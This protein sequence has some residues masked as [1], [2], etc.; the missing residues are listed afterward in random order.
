MASM[1][2]STISFTESCVPERNVQT[3]PLEKYSTQKI[4]TPKKYSLLK[5]FTP[6]NGV[7]G[8]GLV[9]R[10]G[11]GGRGSGGPCGSGWVLGSGW[12]A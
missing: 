9:V 1:T 7:R 5:I 6:G 8:T 12:A 11:G 2:T 10:V 4:L 3:S